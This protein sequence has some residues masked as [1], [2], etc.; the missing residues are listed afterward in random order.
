MFWLEC[1]NFRCCLHRLRL[2]DRQTDGRTG[3]RTNKELILSTIGAL[4]KVFQM[5]LTKNSIESFWYDDDVSLSLCVCVRVFSYFENLWSKW[6]TSEKINSWMNGLG[7]V[8]KCYLWIQNLSSCARIV[9]DRSYVDHVLMQTHIQHFESNPFTSWNRWA[10]QLI[11]ICFASHFMGI[12][13]SMNTHYAHIQA[14]NEPT[15][16]WKKNNN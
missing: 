7:P 8:E 13:R 4:C 11:S 6:A 15:N 5:L 1:R 12:W 2:I 16:K 10:K 3:G 9:L 14:R